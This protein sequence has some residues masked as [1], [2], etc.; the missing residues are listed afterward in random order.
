MRDS[1]FEASKRAW[2]AVKIDEAS[3]RRAKEATEHN[4]ARITELEGALLHQPP[5]AP[6][7]RRP[8]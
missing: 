5:S 3:E 8:W 2:Q 4:T 1:T 7:W 6:A